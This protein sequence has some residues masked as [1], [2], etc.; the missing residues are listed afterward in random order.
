MYPPFGGASESQ[1]DELAATIALT[2]ARPR[3]IAEIIALAIRSNTGPA[4]SMIQA[5]KLLKASRTTSRPSPGFFIAA[6]T[7]AAASCAL[8][9]QPAKRSPFSAT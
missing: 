9:A 7:R 6:P 8:A 3:S 4:L 2:A 5:K 1:L